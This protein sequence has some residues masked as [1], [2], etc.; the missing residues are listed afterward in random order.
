VTLDDAYANAA[1]IPDADRY[2]EGWPA[3]AAAFRAALGP[4]AQTDQTYGPSARQAFDLFRCGED[5][6]GT[7]IFIHGGYWMWF[8]KSDW[9]HLAAGAIKRGWDVALL[10]YDVCP[11]VR[12]PDI[13]RQIA[14]GVAAIAARNAGPISITGHSA[15]GHLAARMLAPGMLVPDVRAR[16]S[17]VAPISPVADLRPLLQTSM[18]K[19]LGLTAADAAAESPLLQPAP[20]TP[21]SLWVGA[22]ERPAFLDQS[23]TLAQAWAVPETR[24]PDRH[25]FNVIDLLCDTDSDILRFLCLSR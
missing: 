13:T 23:A 21:V 25:H 12:I 2:V 8:D 18:N 10:G 5:P 20:A 16:I 24:V 1:Y 15:G 17:A 19:T 7:L 6:R 9:S 14:D 4:R 3:A 11:D 22:E